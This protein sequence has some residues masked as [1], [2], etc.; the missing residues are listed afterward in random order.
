MRRRR[1]TI[2]ARSPTSSLPGR[3][4]TSC[5]CGSRPSRPDHRSS[6]TRRRAPVTTANFLAYVD[7][8]RFDGITF[9]RAARTRGA[10][11]A[12]L[13]PGRHPPQRHG[14]CCRRSRTSRPAGPASAMSTARSRWRAPTPGSAM[15]D[16]FI[17][18]GADAVDGRGRGRRGDISAM[19]PSAGW[20]RGMDI[21]RRILAAPTVAQCRPR[22]DARADDRAAGADHPRA[23]GRNDRP[24]SRLPPRPARPVQGRAA[25]LLWRAR[26]SRGGAR[27]PASPSAR[28]R[29]ASPAPI[30]RSAS[31]PISICRS[32]CSA[33]ARPCR[34]AGGC[35][36]SGRPATG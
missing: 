22:R 16:F 21:V 14:G 4:R 12:R 30:A 13:H 10:H 6:S 33:R 29:C 3:R 34:G 19:P 7:Q 25:R 18:V 2:R 9:Y 28:R 8:H 32:L 11:R 24:A 35:A 23:R 31:P 27:R 26:G 36:I 15:G 17:T 5:G 1:P 20:S